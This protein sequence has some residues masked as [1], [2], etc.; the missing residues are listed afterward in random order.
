MKSVV[1]S[2]Y[3]GLHEKGWQKY[4]HMQ[5]PKQAST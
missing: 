3:I 2:F 4:M 5:A 1:F